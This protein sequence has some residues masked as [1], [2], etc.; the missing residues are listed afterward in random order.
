MHDVQNDAGRATLSQIPVVFLAQDA[1]QPRIRAPGV[2]P[3]S[4]LWFSRALARQDTRCDARGLGMEEEKREEQGV[5]D[6]AV[7]AEGLL[8]L[9]GAGM[10]MEGAEASR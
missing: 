1:M 2:T 6:I 10:A 9:V 7:E 4:T 8:V 5:D 3:K